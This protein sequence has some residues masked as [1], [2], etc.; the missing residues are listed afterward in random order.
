[1]RWP[2]HTIIGLV[3]MALTVVYFVHQWATNFGCD[4]MVYAEHFPSVIKP[5]VKYCIRN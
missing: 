3:L 1:M 4:E 2:S 5:G